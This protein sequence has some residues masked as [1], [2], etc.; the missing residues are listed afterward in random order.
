MGGTSSFCDIP[1]DSAAGSTGYFGLNLPNTEVNVL[2]AYNAVPPSPELKPLPADALAVPGTSFGYA[3]ITDPFLSGPL[4]SKLNLSWNW[5]GVAGQCPA[6]YNCSEG[7]PTSFA[8]WYRRSLSTY[9][10]SYCI[11]DPYHSVAGAGVYADWEND[12][13]P[14]CLGVPTHA[15][16]WPFYI[17]GNNLGDLAAN[18]PGKLPKTAFTCCRQISNYTGHIIEVVMLLK[19]VSLSLIVISFIVA[20]G[21]SVYL[22]RDIILSHQPVKLIF[23]PWVLIPVIITAIPFKQPRAIPISTLM[24]IVFIFSP[25]SLSIGLY[26]V[27]AIAVLLLGT[28]IDLIDRIRTKHLQTRP[29]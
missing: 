1:D 20:I 26:Y 16:Y 29:R 22:I 19:K 27:P 5:T 9:P 8:G 18:F 10:I 7:V 13:F 11:A 6:L 28:I 24:M 2:P 12:T 3:W 14:A 25:F 15:Y 21:T 23:Y 17:E 4:P